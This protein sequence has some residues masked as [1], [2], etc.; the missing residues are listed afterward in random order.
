MPT[1]DDRVFATPDDFAAAEKF[2]RGYGGKYDRDIAMLTAAFARH[3]ELGI[4]E[5]LTRAVTD[6][7]T[8]MT[9]V[10]AAERFAEAL[11][12]HL[13]RPQPERVEQCRQELMKALEGM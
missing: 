7:I 11:R 4:V 13:D 12:V 6:T 2:R 1:D 10:H 5:G 3:R 9:T 8:A